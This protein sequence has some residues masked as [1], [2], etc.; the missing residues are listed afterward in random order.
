[1]GNS[2]LLEEMKKLPVEE[3]LELIEA[4]LHSVREC[5]RAKAR[6]N[7]GLNLEQRMRDAAQ[8]LLPDYENDPEL[9][10]FAVL[11]GDDFHAMG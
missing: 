9:T 11:D 10:C 3:Q 4:S 1:M 6:A 7:N 2:S 5:L 8:R